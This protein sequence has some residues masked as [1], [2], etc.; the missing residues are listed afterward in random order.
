VVRGFI[1]LNELRSRLQK[2]LCGLA[3]FTGGSSNYSNYAYPNKV[4]SYLENGLVA[5]V[6]SQSALAEHS[7][8]RDC[9][10]FVE[11]TSDAIAEAIANLLSNPETA[12]QMGAAGYAY[13]RKL[14][15][16]PDIFRGIEELGEY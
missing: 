13:A 15:M 7:E 10:L 4:K 1:T 2:A 9:C 16:S 14:E 8:L 3:I 6:G 5:L 12:N 11:E